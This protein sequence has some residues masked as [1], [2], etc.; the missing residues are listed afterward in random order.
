MPKAETERCQILRQID[1]VL[2][3][4]VKIRPPK[5]EIDSNLSSV[6][7]KST[8]ILDDSYL[9]K[10]IEENDLNLNDLNLNEF[11]LK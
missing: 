2:G 5:V 8:Q 11:G 1:S 7:K 4:Q 10:K 3:Q 9:E 6:F